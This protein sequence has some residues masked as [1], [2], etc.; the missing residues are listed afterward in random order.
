MI[1][2]SKYVTRREFIKT[3]ILA[4]VGISQI[5]G[6]AVKTNNPTPIVKQP[7]GGATVVIIKSEKLAKPDRSLIK[8][9][10]DIAVPEAL[11]LES[12]EIAWKQLFKPNDYVG[13][14]VN[15]IAPMIP[16]HPELA[17]AIADSLIGV[18]VAPEQIIIW[19]REDRELSMCGY[20][21]NFDG[22]GIRCYGT[23]PRIGYGEDLVVSRSVGSRLSKIISR[24]CTATV[25][26]PVLKDH[27]I[28]GLSMSLKNYFGAIES[29]N[30]F[31]GNNCDP[32]VADL[33]MSPQIKEKNK[34]VICDAIKVL[35][36]GGPTDCKPR[37]TWN[38]NG[39]IV[40]TDM[41]AVDQVALMLLEE[42]RASEG[43]PPLAAVGRPVKYITTAADPEHLL[44]V[45]DP[46]KIR[47]IELSNEA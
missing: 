33:N 23:K 31:H 14:K 27:N 28:A 40:G 43:L 17:L 9:L 24:Q 36:E 13:I 39:I 34:L 29:P 16:T 11:G 45:K 4:G 12:P 42:K 25:N 20:T 47:I 8:S 37:F 30:K 18:G 15:C 5:A 19:D 3:A 10:L 35:F 44:G 1:L 32:F 21:L 26:A 41:V 6:C 22:P 7:T 2:S 38:Y 46:E